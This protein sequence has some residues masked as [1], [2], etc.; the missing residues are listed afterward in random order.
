[1][2]DKE[3]FDSVFIQNLHWQ[4]ALSHPVSEMGNASY[5]AP[6]RIYSIAAALEVRGKSIQM[7]RKHAID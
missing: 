3:S 4:V 6:G 5:I 1:M 7:G 2:V